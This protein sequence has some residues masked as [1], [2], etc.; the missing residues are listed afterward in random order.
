VAPLAFSETPALPAAA[1]VLASAE[2]A[3]ALELGSD[4]AAAP[5]EVLVTPFVVSAETLI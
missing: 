1:G 5:L 2:A 3:L 4:F